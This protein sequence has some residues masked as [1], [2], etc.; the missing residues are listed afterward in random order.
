ML[1]IFVFQ[2]IKALRIKYKFIHSLQLPT[3]TE[4]IIVYEN[5]QLFKEIYCHKKTKF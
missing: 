5:P 1:L 4:P 2:N 3:S